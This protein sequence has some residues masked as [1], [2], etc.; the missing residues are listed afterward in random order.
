MAGGELDDRCHAGFVPHGSRSVPPRRMSH[1][2]RDESG[3]PPQ[4]YDYRVRRRYVPLMGA[5]MWTDLV[6]HAI[7]Q[8]GCE[9]VGATA[10]G[11]SLRPFG[12][13]LLDLA[14]PDRG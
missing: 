11:F 12:C 14:G 3:P 9:G 10:P 7:C 5:A 6:G 2:L 13:G 8:C 4:I 1:A